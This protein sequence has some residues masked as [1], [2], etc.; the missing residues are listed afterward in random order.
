MK[1][2]KEDGQSLVVTPLSSEVEDKTM[3]VLQGVH[4]YGKQFGILTT[5]IAA[6][7]I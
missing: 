1:D 2:C 4:S 7:M 3:C 5:G 6:G